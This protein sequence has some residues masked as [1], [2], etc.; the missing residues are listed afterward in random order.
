MSVMMLYGAHELGC[1]STE[2]ISAAW[3]VFL[4]PNIK[5]ETDLMGFCFQT[6]IQLC[7]LEVKEMWEDKNQAIRL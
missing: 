5:M 3:A 2:E 4:M 7:H 6:S 1:S